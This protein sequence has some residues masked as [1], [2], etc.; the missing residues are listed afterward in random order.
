MRSQ[1]LFIPHHGGFTSSS[2][3]FIRRIFPEIAFVSCG[4]DNIYK[5]PHPEV[6]KRYSIVG[7]KI[8]RT[9]KN[10]AVNIVTDGSNVVCTPFRRGRL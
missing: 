9:D 2:E 6:L 1:V 10:G 8:F 4:F 7:T 5:F 3:A